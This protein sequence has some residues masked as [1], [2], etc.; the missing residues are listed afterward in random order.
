MYYFNALDR[1]DLVMADSN[2]DHDDS[3]IELEIAI[4]Y[5][6]LCIEYVQKHYMKS[7]MCTSILSGKLYVKE[8]L[9]GYP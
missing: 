5:V 9:K 4:V 7:P 1:C 6:Q 2:L 3:D 8:V